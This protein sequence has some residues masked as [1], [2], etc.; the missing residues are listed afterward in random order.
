ME[1]LHLRIQHGFWNS[2]VG[3]PP[4]NC[5][6]IVRPF[7][8]ALQTLAALAAPVMTHEGVDDDLAHGRQD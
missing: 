5:T 7:S 4:G 2:S 3:K 8:Q 1:R 6:R